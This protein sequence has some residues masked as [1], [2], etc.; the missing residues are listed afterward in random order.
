M[1]SGFGCRSTV[2]PDASAVD[3]L[4]PTH[5]RRSSGRKARRTG[6][7]PAATESSTLNCSLSMT[8][9]SP[10]VGIDTN[11]RLSFFGGDPV[12]RR[13]AD[14]DARQSTS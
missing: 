13:A 9:T 10:A 6:L 8:A 11:T 5:N 4:L 14:V 2:T 12:H 7:L 3:A 1:A